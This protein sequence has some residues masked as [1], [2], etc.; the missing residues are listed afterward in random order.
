MVVGMK[1]TLVFHQGRAPRGVRSSWIMHEYRTTEPEYESGEQGSYVLYRLFKKPEDRSLSSNFDAVGR[2]GSSP[3]PSRSS[4]GEG[5]ELD[6]FEGLATPLNQESPESGLQEVGFQQPAG[7]KR[8]LDDKSDCLPT[9]SVKNEGSCRNNNMDSCANELDVG[10]KVE[11]LLDVLQKSCDPQYEPVD[12]DGFNTASS[13]ILPYIDLSPLGNINQG[14]NMRSHQNDNVEN[15]EFINDVLNSMLCN[16]DVYSNSSRGSYAQQD[17]TA[18]LMVPEGNTSMSNISLWD[19]VSV[20]DGTWGS[21]ADAEAG[22][23][24]WG[25]LQQGVLR[26]SSDWFDRPPFSFAQYTE[27]NPQFNNQYENTSLLPY[28]SAGPDV[29]SMDSASESLQELFNSVEEPARQ[30]NP[31]VIED[32]FLGT[33]IQIRA[34]GTQQLQSSSAFSLQGNA[35]RRIRLQCSPVESSSCESTGSNNTKDPE[36]EVATAECLQEGEHQEDTGNEDSETSVSPQ[37]QE[38]EKKS[39]LD[40]K[41]LSAPEMIEIKQTQGSI[42]KLNAVGRNIVQAASLLQ[43]KPQFVSPRSVLVAVILGLLSVGIWGCVSSRAA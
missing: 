22:P 34:R 31:I 7:I 25:V 24:Q 37:N 21:D 16:Q 41:K 19:S 26:E 8:W 9:C 27:I 18:G 20:K 15:D 30:N 42:S 29:Y 12:S 35:Q 28:D 11:S 14:S 33:G 13:P 38:L 32:G 1:K 36:D 43:K 3:T 23:S 10:T 2:G 6:T 4:P 5:L 40:K 17:L 39:C